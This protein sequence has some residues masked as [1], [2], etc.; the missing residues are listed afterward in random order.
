M[1]SAKNVYQQNE[2]TVSLTIK[3]I[4]FSAMSTV[5]DNLHNTNVVHKI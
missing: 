5:N 1:F 3:V 2:M 4:Y